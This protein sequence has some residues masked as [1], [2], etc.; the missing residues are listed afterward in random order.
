MSLSESYRD[1]L[2]PK[3]GK[4]LDIRVEQD[5]GAAAEAVACRG[6]GRARSLGFWVQGLEGPH[7]WASE[8]TPKSH[9]AREGVGVGVVVSADV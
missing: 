1:V 6:G 2:G 4:D 8:S 3:G 7:L 5:L 9:G